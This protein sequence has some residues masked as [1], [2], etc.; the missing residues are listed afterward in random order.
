[1]E[2]DLDKFLE[3]TKLETTIEGKMPTGHHLRGT[4]RQFSFRNNNREL[5]KGPD[6]NPMPSSRQF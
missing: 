3:D 2:E 6:G 1:M 5:S 4:T